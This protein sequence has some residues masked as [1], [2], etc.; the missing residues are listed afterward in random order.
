M[1]KG[2]QDGLARVYAENGVIVEEIQ[3][4]KGNI[5]KSWRSQQ[6]TP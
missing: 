4:R 1:S 3:Y 2:R 6:T 5:I